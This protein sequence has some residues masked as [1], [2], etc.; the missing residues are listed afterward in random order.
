MPVGSGPKIESDK[1][2]IHMDKQESNKES[3]DNEKSTRNE[4][5]FTS[6]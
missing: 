5:P 3:D 2:N 4:K 1:L 6:I